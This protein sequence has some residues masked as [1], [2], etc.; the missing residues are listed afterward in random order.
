MAVP[1]R[2][3]LPV[4]RRKRKMKMAMAMF[5]VESNDGSTMLESEGRVFGKRT[6]S[7]PIQCDVSGRQFDDPL[8][9]ARLQ[10]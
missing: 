4:Q 8:I 7:I 9:M 2:I 1:Q 5:N 10:T 3:R 6:K